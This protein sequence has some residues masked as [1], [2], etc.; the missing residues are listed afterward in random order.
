MTAVTR[1]RPP[2]GV[3][4][5]QSTLMAGYTHTCA[6][7]GTEMSVHERYIGRTLKCTGCRA[8]FI[9]GPAAAPDASIDGPLP[10]SSP[11]TCTACG[12]EMSV[13]RRYYGRTLRCTSCGEEFTARI[14]VVAGGTSGPEAALAPPGPVP[15]HPADPESKVRRTRRLAVGA[16]AVAVLAAVLWYLGGDRAEGFGSFLF[17][18]EKAR[19]QTGELRHGDS[20]TVL[21]ALN[22]DGVDRLL[23][24]ARKKEAVSPSELARIPGF[25]QVTAGTRVRVLERRRGAEARVRILEGPQSSRIVWVPASWVR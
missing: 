24:L 22:R 3:S 6:R 5:E 20:P 23:G 21:V 4:W 8:E 13:A 1:P 17:R 9:A 25:I 14:P 2:A 15:R 11:H 19:T 7:C 16:A 12:T 10:E 18:T